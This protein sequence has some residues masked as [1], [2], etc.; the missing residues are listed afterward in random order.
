[1]EFGNLLDVTRE[2]GAA[3]YAGSWSTTGVTACISTEERE[4]LRKNLM[5]LAEMMECGWPPFR[6]TI[7]NGHGNEA[8]VNRDLLAMSIAVT[9]R[10]RCLIATAPYKVLEELVPMRRFEY[11]RLANN[12][13][14]SYAA[15][16]SAG[17]CMRRG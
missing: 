3:I 13:G 4:L 11:H 17:R 14:V 1:V 7:V 5:R 16:A 15:Y 8:Q 6:Q 2:V 10:I 12:Q 9:T